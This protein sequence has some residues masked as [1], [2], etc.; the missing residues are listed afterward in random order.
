MTIADANE[1]RG[2]NSLSDLDEVSRIV[3]QQKNNERMAAGVTLEDAA[4]T[5]VDVSVSVGPDTII[6]PGVFLEG[7]TTVGAGC[8]IHSGVRITD[9][10]LGDRVKVLNHCVITAAT[11]GNDVSVG[12]FAH[13]RPEAD[14]RDGARGGNFVELKHTVLGPRSKA[15]HLS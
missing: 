8:E 10:R 7:R 6:H 3:M 9:S 1:V 14:V 4:T 13:L 2:M 12:P 11:I 15:L 5:Y